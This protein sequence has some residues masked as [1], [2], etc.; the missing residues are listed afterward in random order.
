MYNN[1]L[2]FPCFSFRQ[3]SGADI[4]IQDPLPGKADRVITISGNPE[5]I[6]YGQ[7]LM[8]QRYDI[9]LTMSNWNLHYLNISIIQR[10][11]IHRQF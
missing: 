6:Q 3:R 4:K 2:F 9:K 8:Q 10:I 5:Q 1:I 7:F 11:H